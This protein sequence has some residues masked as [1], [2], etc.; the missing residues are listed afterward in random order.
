MKSSIIQLKKVK[1]T[2]TFANPHIVPSKSLNK[3]K[4]MKKKQVDH[5]LIRDFTPKFEKK[6]RN[7]S[8]IQCNNDISKKV[9][10]AT[11]NPITRVR[12]VTEDIFQLDK[13]IDNI[14]MIKDKNKLDTDH[15]RR[16]ITPPVG[17]IVTKQSFPNIRLRLP[18][19]IS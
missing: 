7:T 3:T 9:V 8:F 6:P 13:E 11:Q 19:I 15:L 16:S 18:R 4:I 14:I 10:K 1:N 5:K 17:F 2:V 12:K